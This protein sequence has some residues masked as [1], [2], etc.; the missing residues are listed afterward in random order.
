MTGTTALPSATSISRHCSRESPPGTTT[1]AA[2]VGAPQVVVPQA[3]D[4]P[5]WSVAELGIGAA[6][7]GPT[8]TV[9]TLSA[10]L[11]TAL[12]LETRARA[13]ALAGSIRIG[14]ASVAAKLLLDAIGS[15]GR[16]RPREP[17]G[18]SSQEKCRQRGMV[19]CPRCSRWIVTFRSGRRCATLAPGGD[20][21][22]IAFR[23][24][25]TLSHRSVAVAA[26]F[27]TKGVRCGR[28]SSCAQERRVHVK[29]AA[30]N[31]TIGSI[32]TVPVSQNEELRDKICRIRVGRR[33]RQMAFMLVS[34]SPI[35]PPPRAS[36][37]PS[38]G[39]IEIAVLLRAA[40][41]E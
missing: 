2:R 10:A 38:P 16:Q 1:A 33:L 27:Q 37:H 26:P 11:R 14:G 39:S 3:A 24:A 12:S 7:D 40:L 21:T 29:S 20:Q 41:I 13:T 9:E 4:Q 19:R 30:G 34:R 23:K 6:H 22:R 28:E 36:W 32:P 5:Y 15:E 25:Q 31:V 35:V 8:P 17:R 18:S